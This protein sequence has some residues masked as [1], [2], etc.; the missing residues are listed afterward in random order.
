MGDDYYSL[1]S[2]EI[3]QI[4]Q[5]KIVPFIE[6]HASTH[7]QLD[8]FFNTLPLTTFPMIRGELHH[9]IRGL[10]IRS[11]T[12]PDQLDKLIEPYRELIKKSQ[13]PFRTEVGKVIAALEAVNRK[14]DAFS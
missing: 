10:I 8:A 12:F 6:N 13:K 1:F 7:L 9:A 5:L 3:L 2:N 4:Y 14:N 11:L